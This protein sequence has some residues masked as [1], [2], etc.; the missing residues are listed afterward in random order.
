MKVDAMRDYC[1]TLPGTHESVKWGEHLCFCVA[2]KIYA[3]R[4]LDEL[5]KCSVK[6]DKD[7][8]EGFCSQPGHRPAPYLGRYSWIAIEHDALSDEAVM[9]HVKRSYELIVAKLP[10]KLRPTT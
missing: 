10:K 8:F 6:V 1:Q 2:E 9:E 7:L 3:I 5:G 4:D